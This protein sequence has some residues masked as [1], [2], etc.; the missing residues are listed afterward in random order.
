MV[1]P[2]HRRQSHQ[3]RNQEQESHGDSMRHRPI[4]CHPSGDVAAQQSRQ[5]AGQDVEQPDG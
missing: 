1:G 3:K 2:K 5:S 4:G